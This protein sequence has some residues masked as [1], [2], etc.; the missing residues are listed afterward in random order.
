MSASTEPRAAVLL[1]WIA[2]RSPEA[3]ER[4]NALTGSPAYARALDAIEP[5][6][7]RWAFDQTASWPRARIV[8]VVEHADRLVAEGFDRRDAERLALAAALAEGPP[9]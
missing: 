3:A 6:W 9:R 2:A 8:A 4:L 7:F 5:R 1:P